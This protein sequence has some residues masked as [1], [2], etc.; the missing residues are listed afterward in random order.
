MV[1]YN[2]NVVRNLD[3]IQRDFSY[4]IVVVVVVVVVAFLAFVAAVVVVVVVV[5]DGDLLWHDVL[6]FDRFQ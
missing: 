5:H 1:S 3:E 6:I 4:D 2:R